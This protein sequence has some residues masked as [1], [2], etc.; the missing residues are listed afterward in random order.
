MSGLIHTLPIATTALALSFATVLFRH[1]WQKKKA[2]YVAWWTLGVCAYGAGTLVEGLTTLFGWSDLVFRVWYVCGALLGAAPLAQGTA[3]LLL[4]RKT[5]HKLTLVL[6]V[7][8]AIASAGAFLTP[9][10]Y[11]RVE[12]NRLSARVI[13]W[14]WIRAFSPFINL[15][16]LALL[17]GG[18]IYSA[19]RYWTETGSRNRFW[20]NVWIAFGSLLPGVGGT[21]ARFGRTEWLYVTELVALVLI[22]LGYWLIRN[23]PG[24]SLHK[25]Q[26]ENEPSSFS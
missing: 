12:G 14:Q 25:A 9:I 24:K 6:G 18:A 17:V 8:I 10:D 15:Y 11:S 2:L 26:A 19:W 5:A 4:K 13:Q 23:D 21:F 16:A 20:G 7:I 22:W 1:W 3:Y